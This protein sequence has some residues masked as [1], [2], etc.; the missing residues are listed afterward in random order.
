[1]KKELAE[2]QK[3]EP[4]QLITKDQ[5]ICSEWEIHYTRQDMLQ[6]IRVEDEN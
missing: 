3:R 4:A 5:R 6:K 2:I 1:M